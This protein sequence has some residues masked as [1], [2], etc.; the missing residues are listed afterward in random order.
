M[1]S[2]F[3][4]LFRLVQRFLHRLF[5]KPF[6]KAPCREISHRHRFLTDIVACDGKKLTVDLISCFAHGLVFVSLV[7]LS[8]S[9]IVCCQFSPFRL[10]LSISTRI[11]S[12]LQERYACTGQPCGTASAVPFTANVLLSEYMLLRIGMI[13]F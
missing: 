5:Q 12:M 7:Q 1:A 2:P 3:F 13:C 11:G 9:S 4:Y 6:C 10:R 8:K